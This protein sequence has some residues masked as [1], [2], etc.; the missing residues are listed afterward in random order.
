MHIS[1]SISTNSAGLVVLLPAVGLLLLMGKSS[2]ESE[3]CQH[4]LSLV[5]VVDDIL[6]VSSAHPQGILILHLIY[7]N[8]CL[9][10]QQFACIYACARPP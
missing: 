8:K 3:L 5:S 10:L 9:N 7:H 4:V 2:S 6:L 1:L